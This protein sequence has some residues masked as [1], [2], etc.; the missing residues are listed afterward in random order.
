MIFLSK[1]KDDKKVVSVRFTEEEKAKLERCTELC[2]LSQT[3]FIRQLCR[4]QMPKPQPTK[5]F[6][7]LMNG[8][9]ELHSAFEKCIPFYPEV[10]DECREIERFIL[11]LQEAV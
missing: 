1:K 4:G 9:Y 3:E 11:E 5:E 6:W 7:E 10:I 8:I 2:G